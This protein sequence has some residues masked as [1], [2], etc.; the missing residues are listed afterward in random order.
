MKYSLKKQLRSFHYAWNGLRTCAR[1]EQNLRFHLVAAVVATGA[2]WAFDISRTEWAL[3]CLCIGLVIGAEVMN[4][5]IERLV[6]LVSPERQPLAGLVKDIAAGGVL[7][8]AIT[9]AVVGVIIF[10]PHV[11]GLFR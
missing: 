8:C 6:D 2:G 9:A 4:T 10:W 11:A 5:A 3:V 1:N 7:V